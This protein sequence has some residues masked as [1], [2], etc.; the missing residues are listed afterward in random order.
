ML[1]AIGAEGPQPPP[2]PVLVVT[3][4]ETP[5][6]GEPAEVVTEDGAVLPADGALPAGLPPGYHTL[7]RLR[8][9]EELRLIVCPP[10]CHPP[11]ERR[12]WGWAAQLY[13]VRSRASWGIGDLADLRDLARWSAGLGAGSPPPAPN[14]GGGGN[15]KAVSAEDEVKLKRLRDQSEALSGTYG[16]GLKG[17]LGSRDV[18][19]CP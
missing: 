16:W 17:S 19:N 1:A 12:A 9:G 4:G 10:T 8:R 5:D 14:T 15:T 6:P 11:D 18:P 3:E 2:A 13:A 7:R